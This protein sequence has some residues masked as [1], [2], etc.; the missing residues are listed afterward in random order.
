[1]PPEDNRA[2]SPEHW[3]RFAHSDL[4]LAKI[5][6]PKGVLLEGLCFHAHQAAEKALKAVLIYYRISFPM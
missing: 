1:M 6:P 5:T 4:E 2:G 3:M